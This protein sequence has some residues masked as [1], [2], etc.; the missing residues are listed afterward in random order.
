MPFDVFSLAERGRSMENVSM[1]RR[2]DTDTVN[3]LVKRLRRRLAA[4]RAAKKKPLEEVVWGEPLHGEGRLPSP[5]NNPLLPSKRT[6]EQ[7]A[8]VLD[9]QLL[10][11]HRPDPPEWSL[12]YR[13]FHLARLLEGLDVNALKLLIEQ[14]EEYLQIAKSYPTE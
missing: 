13:L 11:L 5:V 12:S 8:Q 1:S 10:D 7:I 14:A 6:L 4:L 2:Q 3:P 9:V